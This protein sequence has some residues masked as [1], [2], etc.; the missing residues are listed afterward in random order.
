MSNSIIS[1]I[2]ID[3]EPR[4]PSCNKMLAFKVA[5][6]WILKCLRCKNIIEKT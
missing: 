6:P 4:C 1:E 2:T 3:I 5:R